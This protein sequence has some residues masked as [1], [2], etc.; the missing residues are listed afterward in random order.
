MA[1]VLFSWWK[2]ALVALDA[3]E[4]FYINPAFVALDPFESLCTNAVAGLL[5]LVS[6]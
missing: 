5:L 4:V 6:F 2:D 1:L 3:L